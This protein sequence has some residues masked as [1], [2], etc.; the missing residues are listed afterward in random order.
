MA[1][2]ALLDATMGPESNHAAVN[3]V[4]QTRY[5]SDTIKE[6]ETNPDAVIQRLNT[7][8]TARTFKF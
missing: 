6:L 4:R 3:I 5:L 2:V 1:R 8:R 7:L